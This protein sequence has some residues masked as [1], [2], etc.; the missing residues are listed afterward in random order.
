LE[1]PPFCERAWLLPLLPDDDA[2][3]R[4]DADEERR[5]E[6]LLLPLVLF[7][8]V[9]ERGWLFEALLLFDP[10]PLFEAFERLLPELRADPLAFDPFELWELRFCLLDDRVF[11]CAMTPPWVST[12]RAR[13]SHTPVEA[14]ETR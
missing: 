13:K 1:L 7:A 6:A 3:L 9:L 14:P 4:D 12:A 10:L 11:A 2:R 8:L 5:A